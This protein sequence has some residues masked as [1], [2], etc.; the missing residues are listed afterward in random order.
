LTRTGSICYERILCPCNVEKGMQ[1][2]NLALE[3]HY[4]YLL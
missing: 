3:V 2:V 4:I 1:S